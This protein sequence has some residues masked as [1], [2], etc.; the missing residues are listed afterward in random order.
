MLLQHAPTKALSLLSTRI[1]EPE[2]ITA[3][4]GYELAADRFH[5]NGQLRGFIV[6]A[7]AV[8]VP[9]RFYH[10]FAEYARLR[11]YVVLTFDYR[12]IGRSAPESLDGFH[13]DFRDWGSLDL[14]AVVEHAAQES[15]WH[16]VPLYVVAHSFGGHA[17]G[18]LPNH[19]RVR[20]CYLYGTGAGWHGYMPRTEQLKVLALWNVVG[21][22]LA[23][24]KRYL[25]WSLIGM[26]ED[27]PLNVYRQWRRWCR[28]PHYFFDDPE[29]GEEMR[30]MYARVRTTL[31]AAAATDDLWSPP[32]SRDAFLEGYRNAAVRMLNYHPSRMRIGS[33]GHMGFFRQRAASLWP[34]AIDL[35]ES[36]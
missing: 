5:V 33:L 23:W 24:W 15:E 35:L 25:A 7:G 32:R 9:Q 22:T 27:L 11:G 26:G 1:P 36:A 29:I 17:F 18:M 20:A 14:A 10:R 6:I 31:F 4:D 13:M 3:A 19:E 28:Y 12:G 30:A 2:T 34:G 16:G 21:P 8:G